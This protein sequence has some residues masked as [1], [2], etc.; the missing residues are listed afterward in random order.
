MIAIP[1]DRPADQGGDDGG[2][3]RR[4]ARFNAQRLEPAG[5]R[6]SAQG[7]HEHALLIA[8]QNDFVERERD[9]V[10]PDAQ[11]APSEPGAFVAWF[12]ELQEHGAGQGDGLFPWLAQCA[13][14]DEMRWF[15][16]QEATG[17]AGFDDLVAL[18]QVKLPIRAKLELARNFWDEMGRGAPESMHGGLLDRLIRHL[19]I[20]TD[21]ERTA[22]PALAVGNLMVGL[23]TQRHYAYQSIGAL[24]VI[25]LTAPDRVAQVACGLRRLGVPAQERA[26]YEIHATLDRKHSRAWNQEVIAPL[27]EQDPA[28]ARW[29]AEGALMRLAAGARCFACY[30]AVLLPE[31]ALAASCR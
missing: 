8:L 22:W 4:L 28:I 6:S 11:A 12:T 15:L 10:Q 30:R 26:Y 18:T 23:A 21:R 1:P 3:H 31:G 5:P 27:L 19:G 9:K 17:E 13:S 24:G 16:A 14:L 29:I 20:R 25:E 7:D 2:L